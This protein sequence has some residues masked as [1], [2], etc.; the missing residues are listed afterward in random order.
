MSFNYNQ[1]FTANY[2]YPVIFT[3]DVF[4]PTNKVFRNI[5][6]QAGN[7]QHR[8][9]V[10]IDSGVIDNHPR[11]T[12][13]INLYFSQHKDI[14]LKTGDCF[15]I[16]GGEIAKQDFETI[17]QIYQRIADE[18]ICRHSFVVVIGGGAVIDAVGYAVATAHRGVRL[19]RFPTTVLAQN[20]AGL[21]V[22]NAINFDNRKNFIGTFSPPWAVISDYNFLRSLSS[23]DK[24]AGMAE[25]VKIALVK[26]RDFFDFLY[27]QRHALT[28]F[29][30][31]PLQT[32]I[33][34]CAKLHLEHIAKGGDPFEQGSARPLDFGHWIAHKLEELSHNEIKHGEAV[35]I[36]IT[37]DSHYSYQ[38]GWLSEEELKQILELLTTLGFVVNAPL[39]NKVNI[40]AALDEFRQHLG[41]FL[42]ITLLKK[43]GV[44]QEVE[45]I[46]IEIMK[47]SIH[48]ITALNY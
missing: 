21:G 8:V 40:E 1:K 20:D 22:K 14:M 27:R 4:N 44:G 39:L 17:H 46:D 19:I 41:G 30:D 45:S 33:E 15:S 12:T 5:L 32:L 7:H 6:V 26:D 28:N 10:I 48:S 43:I 2:E 31:Q 24:R 36:G 9:L 38:L 13:Q 23:S 42:T 16:P 3:H 34:Q 18:K 11:L 25:A 47:N 29:E 37:V 35:A